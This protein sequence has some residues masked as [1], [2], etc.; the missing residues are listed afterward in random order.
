MITEMNGLLNEYILLFKEISDNMIN[1]AKNIIDYN[2]K[3]ANEVLK[4]EEDIINY[5]KRRYQVFL[6]SGFVERYFEYKKNLRN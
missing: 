6:C 3:L 1:E 4:E 2:Y 5:Y